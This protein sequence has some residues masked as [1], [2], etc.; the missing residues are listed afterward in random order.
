MASACTQPHS[1]GLRTLLTYPLT[2]KYLNQLEGIKD[3]E[4]LVRLSL[5]VNDNPMFYSAAKTMRRHCLVSWAPAACSSVRHWD[6]LGASPVVVWQCSCPSAP[7]SACLSTC[8]RCSID[9]WC[10]TA[11]DATHGQHHHAAACINGDPIAGVVCTAHHCYSY[12]RENCFPT[13]SV[14]LTRLF[15]WA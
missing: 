12:C 5:S 10:N 8:S 3:Y 6:I 2:V 13:A 14:R 9:A 4:N 1:A 15:C 11:R 7:S